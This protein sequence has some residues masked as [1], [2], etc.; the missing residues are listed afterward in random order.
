MSVARDEPPVGGSVMGR[1]EG[2]PQLGS[3]HARLV[4]ANELMPQG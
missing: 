1:F 4:D 3:H 2:P